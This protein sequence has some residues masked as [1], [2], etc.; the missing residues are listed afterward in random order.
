MAKESTRASRN[1]M[2]ERG[3]MDILLEHARNPKF[4]GRMV[5]LQRDGEESPSS[6]MMH[7]HWHISQSNKSKRRKKN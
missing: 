1:T 2:Y 5:G 6:S 4:K 7:F 3:L